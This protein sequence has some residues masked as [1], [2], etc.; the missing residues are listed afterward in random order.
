MLTRNR[1]CLKRKKKICCSGKPRTRILDTRTVTM[2]NPHL[3]I[4]KSEWE[5]LKA[6]NV[7]IRSALAET[8]GK[9]SIK[10]KRGDPRGADTDDASDHEDGLLNGDTPTAK[11]HKIINSDDINEDQE[12][13]YDLDSLLP[14]PQKEKE[15]NDDVIV[16][17]LVEIEQ[18]YESEDEKGPKVPKKKNKKKKKGVIAKMIKG[19]ITDD[20]LKEK[21]ERL[22]RP[23]NCELVVP[24]VN[25]VIWAIMDHKTRSNDL[26][27]Q[28]EQDNVSQVS[29]CADKSG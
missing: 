16:Y 9:E 3:T 21:T 24:K 13:G 17:A 26:R 7:R 29:L 2:N 6:Q 5:A 4:T 1:T 10:R 19:K 12:E 15:K 22:K 25:P 8:L 11:K 28:K 27:L 20:K 23:E 18:E 14:A